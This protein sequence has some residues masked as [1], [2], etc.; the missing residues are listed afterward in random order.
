M[1]SNPL[2]SGR[3]IQVAIEGKDEISGTQDSVT[4]HLD[5]LRSKAGLAGLAIAGL[6]T[7]LAVDAVNSASE[8]ESALVDLEKVAGSGVASGLEDDIQQMAEEIPLTA[9]ELAGLASDAARFGVEGEDSILRFVEA[10]SK[11]AT[12][13]T[14]NT[15]QAAQAFAKLATLTDTPIGDIKNLGSSINTLS[16]NFAASSQEI[17]DAS[18][19][20]AGALSQLGLE[21]DAIFG[22]NTAMTTVSESAD[23]AGSRLRR[24][25]QQVM[26]PDAAE[27]FAE[28]LGLTAEGFN[29]MRAE[30]PKALLVDLI[31]TFDDGGTAAE[32]LQKNLSSTSRQAL[33][34]LA[35]NADGVTDALGT[36]GESFKEGESLQEEFALESEKTKTQQ[37]LLRSEIENVKRTLGSDLLPAFKST[38]GVVSDVVS[39]FSDLNKATDGAAAKIGVFAAIVGG[40]GAAL[41][42]FVGGPITAAVAG[43]A[44]LGTAY[45]TNLGGI[46]DTTNR[47]LSDVKEIWGRTLGDTGSMVQSL[48]GRLSEMIG[49]QFDDSV[50][51]LNV[52]V[53]AFAQGL[54]VVAAG[55]ITLLD[56]ALSAGNTVKETL[57]N[58]AAAASEL[59]KGNIDAAKEA[60][61]SA[62]QRPGEGV[63]G[64]LDRTGERAAGLRQR[65]QA[66]KRALA[67]GDLSLLPS[68]TDDGSGTSQPSSGEG[69]GDGSDEFDSEA[70]AEEFADA[71]SSAQTPTEDK[72]DEILNEN[73]RTAGALEGSALVQSDS[74]CDISEALLDPLKRAPRAHDPAAAPTDA[75]DSAAAPDDASGASG[76]SGTQGSPFAAPGQ[77]GIARD[78]SPNGARDTTHRSVSESPFAAPGQAGIA[79]DDGVTVELHVDGQK[80]A[81]ENDRASRKYIESTRVTE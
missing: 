53:T 30:N 39:A 7:A 70:V 48:L 42:A 72:L 3:S 6:G 66:R 75:G 40:A 38:I 80:L 65:Q 13:T 9:N 21:A 63:S 29:E 11:M 62:L 36:A 8:F 27:D 24:L 74:R 73:E 32:A 59:K 57:A 17:T 60:A 67:T 28:P 77:A 51:K 41:F 4:Q 71:V 2:S 12:A 26:Q 55:F 76:P 58:V 34:G 43:L 22:L 5:G 56:A 23:R 19:R 15:D 18:L 14:L 61:Q 37:Q 31:E 16:N 68:A 54:D 52:F 45:A 1:V 49:L 50:S 47:V 78:D 79:R 25:T 81:E 69:S 46:R 35:Q 44:A 10:T 20:S 33:A 64:F